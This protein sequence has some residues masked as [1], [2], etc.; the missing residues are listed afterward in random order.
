MKS[1]FILV[2]YC[3]Y[4]SVFAQNYRFIYEYK[5]IPQKE[6]KDSLIIEYMNL[7]TDGKRSLF[8]NDSKYKMDSAY[9]SS[10]NINQLIQYKNYNQNLSYK[11]FKDYKIPKIN[12]YSK[13]FNIDIL[14][15]EKEL[16]NWTLV[17]EFSVI[18]TYNCQ[19][20]YTEYKGRIWYAWFTK[21]IPIS[22]GPY[23]FTGLPG[24]I[25]RIHD[26]ELNHRF[27]LVQVINIKVPFIEIP[28]KVKIMTQS[29]YNELEKRNIN[30]R[31]DVLFTNVTNNTVTVALNNGTIMNFAKTKKSNVDNEIIEKNRHT[32]NP[33]E[34][35][36]N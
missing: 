28:K 2:F 33:I 10:K 13:K 9:S 5:F 26:K 19:K 20:A 7:D 27:D 4:L 6:K 29:Q 30:I 1:F 12:F 23:K 35:I 22:D 3:L 36:T 24:L 16:P 32:N 17:D 11:I 34:L 25:I 8:F 31:T 14:V 21:D 18:N 15:E